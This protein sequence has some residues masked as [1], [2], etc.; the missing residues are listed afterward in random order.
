MS[1]NDVG[2]AELACVI[3]ALL[4]SLPAV[5]SDKLVRPRLPMRVVKHRIRLVTL[6]I[7]LRI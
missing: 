4:V 3:A 7:T 1:T 5:L 2:G 6:V